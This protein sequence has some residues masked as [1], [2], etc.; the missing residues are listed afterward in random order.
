MGTTFA[1]VTMTNMLDEGYVRDG[2][3]KP[4]DVRSVTVRALVD[5]GAMS[6]I[7]PE[8]LRLKLGLR[9]IGDSVTKIADGRHVNCKV[10]EGVKFCWKNREWILSAVVIPGAEDVLLGAI[11]LE[12]LDVMVNPVTQELVG[13]HGEKALYR[14]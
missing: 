3:I 2:Y 14:A 12:A 8:E 13:I 9:I 10:T 4:D 7:I 5:T 11:P 1:E 6:L